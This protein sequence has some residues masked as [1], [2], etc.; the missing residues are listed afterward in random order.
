MSEEKYVKAVRTYADM[1]FRIAVNYC[2]GVQDAED[3]VQDVFLKLYQHGKDFSDEE[4]LKRWLIRVTVNKSKD[5]LA[6]SWHKR[7]GSL[8]EAERKLVLTTPEKS[9][10]YEAVKELPAKYRIVVHLYYYEDYSVKEIAAILRR[11]ETTIQTQLMRGRKMLKEQL[12]AS[13]Q[14]DGTSNL[15]RSI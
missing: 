4:H 10:L 7:V 13:Q 2:K 5:L 15:Q 8:A 9:E 12:N 11:K 1:V 14:A 6:S 3:I